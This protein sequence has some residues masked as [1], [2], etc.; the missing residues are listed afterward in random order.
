MSGFRFRIALAVSA[1]LLAACASVALAETFQQ[2]G[3]RLTVDGDLAPIKLPRDHAAPISV[4]VGGRI[5]TPDKSP[6]PRLLELAV[7][8]N[9]N[10][11][12]DSTG[13]PIC[14]YSSIQPASSTRA[15]SGCRPALIGIGSFEAEIA[16]PGQE[17][18]QVK[19]RMLAFNGRENGKSVIFAHIYAPRPFPNSFVLV[20]KIEQ[21]RKGQFGTKLKAKLPPE[22]ASWGKLTGI[23]LELSRR[24]T[25]KGERHSYL[26]AGCPTPKGVGAVSFP[27]ARTSFS[28]EGG[29]SISGTILRRCEVR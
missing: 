2:G 21:L 24:Y 3:L 13:L 6:P 9:R 22:L 26:S 17:V 8:L 27:L 16:L 15:L 14:A 25:Y 12:I 11:R 4:T 10:G 5:S 18:S 29:K 19:G 20:F 23:E 1:C 7:D 28:F